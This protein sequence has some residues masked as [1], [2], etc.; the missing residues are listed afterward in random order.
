[1]PVVVQPIIGLLFIQM[2]SDN[3]LDYY[4]NSSATDH[5]FTVYS[6]GFYIPG[7]M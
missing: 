2:V 6:N 5:R 7:G 1:M 4:A 3:K